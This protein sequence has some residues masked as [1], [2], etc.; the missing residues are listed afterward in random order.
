MNG[1]I[2]ITYKFKPNF[3][4]NSNRSIKLIVKGT[5]CFNNPNKETFLS[6]V[7]KIILELISIKYRFYN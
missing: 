7:T 2:N 6:L 1:R 3:I 5:I 4:P